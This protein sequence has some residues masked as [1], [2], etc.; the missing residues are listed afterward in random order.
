MEVGKCQV[1]GRVVAPQLGRLR[2]VRGSFL[3]APKG[4]QHLRHVERAIRVAVV[5]REG[6]ADELERG[7]VPGALICDQAEKMERMRMVAVEGEHVAAGPFGL[8]ESAG[9]EMRQRGREQIAGERAGTGWRCAARAALA[10][11]A[12][13]LA[14]HGLPKD[15][16]KPPPTP[17][18]FP[19][20]RESGNILS[21]SPLSR[22]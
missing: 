19:R 11:R 16:V 7:V 5:Q 15:F 8:I 9:A 17:R 1:S 4:A 2:E 13:I 22:P 12:P 14:V 10:R 3:D 21:A 18:S 6:A 20:K